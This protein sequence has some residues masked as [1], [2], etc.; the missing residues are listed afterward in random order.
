MKNKINGRYNYIGDVYGVMGELIIIEELKKKK[1]Q[2]M[3]VMRCNVC[4]G[5]EEVSDG[6]LRIGN[7]GKCDCDSVLWKKHRGL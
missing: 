3:F 7:Y 6:Q 4:G 1:S 5:T 2:R